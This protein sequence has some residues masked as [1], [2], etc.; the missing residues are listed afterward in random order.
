MWI[1][2]WEGH[3]LCQVDAELVDCRILVNPLD[4]TYLNTH[5]LQTHLFLNWMLEIDFSPISLMF[6]FLWKYLTISPSI[7][8]LLM[9]PSNVSLQ[10]P[11]LWILT[12]FKGGRSLCLRMSWQRSAGQELFYPVQLVMSPGDFTTRGSV[13]WTH[14]QCFSLA[15]P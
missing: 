9:F 3:E 13:T 4:S 6:G 15:H 7:T 10:G 8:T 5:L 14:V 2:E 11:S 12:R 1:P